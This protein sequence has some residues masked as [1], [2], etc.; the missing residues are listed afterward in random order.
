MIYLLP[1]AVRESAARRP[2]HPAFRC[3]TDQLTYAELTDRADRLATVLHE[4]GVRMGD[5]VGVCLPRCI[6]VPVAIYAVMRLG[7]IFVPLNPKAPAARSAFQLND[8]GVNV[9]VSHPSQRRSLIPLLKAETGLTTLLGAKVDRPDLHCSE[10]S[11]INLAPAAP[12]PIPP[13]L[14]EDDPAYLIYTSGSTG[15]PKAIVHTHRSGL[16]FARLMVDTFGLTRDDIFGNHAPVYFDVSQLALFAAPLIGATAV[17]ATDAHTIF[18]ASLSQLIQDE[19]I[20]VWYSVPLALT[21]MLASGQLADR[22]WDAL[23]WIFYAGEPFAPRPLARLMEAL[24]RTRVAN[25]YG[26]AETNVCT[27]YVLPGPPVDDEAVPLGAA[28]ANTEILLVDGELC[29]RS[30]TMMRGYWQRPALNEGA[31]LERSGPDGLPVRYYRSGDLAEWGTDGLL[32]F[33][34]RRDSQV[35]I[36]GY[37]VELGAVEAALTAH[38]GVGEAVALTL[39]GTEAAVLVAAVLRNGREVTERELLLHLG[40][41]LPAYAVPTTIMVMDGFPRTGSDKVDRPALQ[42]ELQDIWNRR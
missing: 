8:C 25:L 21:Q 28:W 20:T 13:A 33:G 1:H 27:A 42:R 30:P 17:L 15:D 10:W 38:D 12:P 6:E 7:A 24:P 3:G 9:L 19:G 41:R 29:I 31:F 23:R 40:Q 14:T 34:G 16:A 4:S 2:D 18:P 22:N 32:R 26:P 37:R 11:D 5:R 39:A 35:K 36:R